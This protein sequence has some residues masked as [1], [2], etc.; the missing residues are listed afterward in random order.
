MRAEGIPDEMIAQILGIKATG[1][2]AGVNQ[3]DQEEDET[4]DE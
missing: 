1:Q 3:S 4:D 2:P